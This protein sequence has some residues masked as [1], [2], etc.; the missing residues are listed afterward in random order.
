LT[1]INKCKLHELEE[2]EFHYLFQ[3]F[4]IETKVAEDLDCK[5][6]NALGLKEK[7][8]KGRKGKVR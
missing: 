3:T 7:E 4:F 1:E 6:T 5:K 2:T 8:R